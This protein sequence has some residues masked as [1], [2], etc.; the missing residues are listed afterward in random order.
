MKKAFTIFFLTFYSLGTLLFPM[1]DL[2][3]MVDLPKMFHHCQQEDNDMD[4]CDFVFEHLLNTDDIIGNHDTD[5][6]EQDKPH[7]PCF[8][9]VA[10]QVLVAVNDP[11]VLQ[12]HTPR[13]VKDRK[14]YA[15]LQD[16]FAGSSHLSQVF[17]PPIIA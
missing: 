13:L 9:H 4:V 11:I 8:S 15:M 3:Y 10:S 2:S 14:T 7:T 16:S 12:V 6:R 5:K 17:R 1:G